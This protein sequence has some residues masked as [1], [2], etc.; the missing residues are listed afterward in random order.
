MLQYTPIKLDK[1]RNLRYGMSALMI[2]EDELKMPIS[3][4]DFNNM[5]IRTLG[6]ILAAGLKH[7]QAD[8]TGEQVINLI[9]EY[10]DITDATEALGKA[11]GEAFGKKTQRT[12][13]KNQTV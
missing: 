5:T 6:I 4:I 9:D 7:E 2:I 13:A 3:K 1:V 8:I 10:G 11:M 12:A